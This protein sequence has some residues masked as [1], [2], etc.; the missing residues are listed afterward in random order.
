M[1]DAADSV[2]APELTMKR[3]AVELAALNGVTERV[4]GLLSSARVLRVLVLFALVTP[5]WS[6]FDQKASTW[7]LQ[8]DAMTKP[9]WFQL[10]MFD[11]RR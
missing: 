9:S 8:A 11:P 2:V 1:I 4:F 6:L 5:F 3:G 7:V 10:L